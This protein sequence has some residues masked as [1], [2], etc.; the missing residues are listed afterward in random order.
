MKKILLYLLLLLA[1]NHLIAL[2]LPSKAANSPL[3]DTIYV[4]Q[5]A[6]TYLLFPEEVDMLDLGIGEGYLLKIEGRCVF[7][8]A[9]DSKAPLTSLLIKYGDTYLL[10]MLAYTPLPTRYLHDFRL[11][12]S[13]KQQVSRKQVG[14][15]QLGKQPKDTI[16]T[17]TISTPI[18]PVFAAQDKLA[19]ISEQPGALQMHPPDALLASG[20]K[21]NLQLF[22][23]QVSLDTGAIYLALALANESSMDFTIAYISFEILERKGRYFS[24]NNQ[25]RKQQIP[26]A[27]LAPER[28]LAGKKT[29]MLYALPL[30]ALRAR[31][32][33]LIT[34]K[35]AS[36]E[37]VL[38]LRIPARLLM[39]AQ[40][41]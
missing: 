1:G 10:T 3:V 12:S 5:A 41:R 17:H 16:S 2:G 4:S 27:S 20:K 21:D 19:S 26:L 11:Q 9:K 23:S 15:K 7:I 13:G 14:R 18:D 25:N 34:L 36:G 37:R 29:A 38:R 35:E 6:T 28:L 31:S 39:N 40:R 8:K 30:Y 24:S 22:L 33:L 32:K